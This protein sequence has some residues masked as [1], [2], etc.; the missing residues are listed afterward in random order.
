M[1]MKKILTRTAAVA[2]ALLSGF[3][4]RAQL[5][6]NISVDGKYAPQIIRVDRLNVFPNAV[7]TA[8]QVKPLPYEEMGITAPFGPKLLAIQPTAWQAKRKISRSR[9]YLSF[10]AGS[11]L[12]STLSA[13]YRIVDNTSAL[14]GIRLQHNSTSLWKPRVSEATSGVRQFRYDESLGLYGGYTFKGCGRI[15]AALDWHFGRFNYYSWFPSSVD[16]TESKQPPVQT[17]NDVALRIDWKPL[18]SHKSNVIWHA[19]MDMRHF[20]F[21]SLPLP[22]S[23][24]GISVTGARE[25][26]LHLNASAEAPSTAETSFG[27][28]ADL[29]IFLPNGNLMTAENAHDPVRKSPV[30]VTSDY[31]IL[32]LNPYW[33]YQRG[34]ADIRIGADI[35]ISANAGAKG[36]RYPLFHIAPDIRIALQTGQLALF[37]AAKG[38][39]TPNTMA[40]LWQLDYYCLPALTST[41]PSFTPFNATAGITIG[42]YAGFSASLKASYRI[43]RN[44]PAGGWYMDWLDYGSSSGPDIPELSEGWTYIQNPLQSKGIDLRGWSA[45]GNLSYAWGNKFRISAEAFWQP[46]KAKT[47]YFNGYDRPE[48]TSIIK[49]EGRPVEKLKLSAGFELRARRCIYT[50]AELSPIPG[51]NVTIIEGQSTLTHGQP[52][53]S[54]QLLNAGVSWD[55]TPKFS[56]WGEGANILNRRGDVLPM[57]PM[58]G[59]VVTAGLNL[60]F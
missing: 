31:C 47:G 1:E 41:R 49:A 22:Q 35:D 42:E 6:E 57:Q 17:L 56:V 16:G 3:A 12:N 26:E 9:G 5:H 59:L 30:A 48:I 14:A 33:S 40:R 11:W 19:G 13:G 60:I 58:Q 24:G 34:L 43:S 23:Y 46:Q 55:V 44:I 53:P 29:G 25:T 45:G 2:V 37:A 8:I 15:D 4:P 21:R 10:G 32:T 51:E 39:T 20:A 38:G 18:S 7:A 27:V 54:L 52:L 28:D 50:V 36:H